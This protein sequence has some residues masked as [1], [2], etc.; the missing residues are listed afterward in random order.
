[1]SDSIL[2]YLDF[3]WPKMVRDLPFWIQRQ[4]AGIGKQP[5][6]WY[7]PCIEPGRHWDVR[8]PKRI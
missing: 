7:W 1:M 8:I 3:A 2:I 5:G 6:S 4:A